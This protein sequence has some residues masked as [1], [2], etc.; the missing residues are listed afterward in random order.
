[1]SGASG[2]YPQKMKRKRY[3]TES[4]VMDHVL[5]MGGLGPMTQEAGRGGE[6][7]GVYGGDVYDDDDD[8]NEEEEEEEERPV[9]KRKGPPVGS[10]CREQGC[11]KWA[12]S[13]GLCVKHGGDKR[14]S[15]LVEGCGTLSQSRGLCGKLSLIHI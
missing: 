13:G 15:C 11:E 4:G 8:S 3:S 14:K 7:A 5:M 6:G 10:A 12:V 1:M 2:A 9:K